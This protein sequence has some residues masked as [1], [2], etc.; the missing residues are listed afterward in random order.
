MRHPAPAS[1][2][3]VLASG[4]GRSTWT[5]PPCW[6]APTYEDDATINATKRLPN[7]H[8]HLTSP[9]PSEMPLC[10]RRLAARSVILARVLCFGS[11]PAGAGLDKRPRQGGT[12][13]QGHPL[14]VRIMTGG[15]RGRA[16]GQRPSPR[17]TCMAMEIGREQASASPSRRDPASAERSPQMEGAN[18]TRD[19]SIA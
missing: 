4:C 7:T 9:A 19:T 10:A 8:N 14:R 12:H 3:F 13:G 11:R 15:Q 1:R 2:S 6:R 5:P 17:P 16:R 18:V